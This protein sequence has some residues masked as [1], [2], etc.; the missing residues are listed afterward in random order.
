MPA[1]DHNRYESNETIQRQ[2]GDSL[3]ATIPIS[4]AFAEAAEV[5]HYR[6]IVVEVGSTLYEALQSS[7]WLEQFPALAIWCEQ[8]KAIESPTAKQWHVGVFSQKQ[9]LNYVLKPHDRVEVY[10]SLSL[11]PMGKRKKRA[12]EKRQSS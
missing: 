9:P 12:I 4:L 3:N 5:Q 11:D 8:V 1:I 7:G 2:T 6:Q 10:R